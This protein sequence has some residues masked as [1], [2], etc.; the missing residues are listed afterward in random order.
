M[1]AS[2]F[3]SKPIRIINQWEL[4]STIIVPKMIVDIITTRMGGFISTGRG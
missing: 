4:N 3:I 1:I 2:I